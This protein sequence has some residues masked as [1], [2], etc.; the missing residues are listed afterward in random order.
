MRIH[1][2]AALAAVIMLSGCASTNSDT[3]ATPSA[4]VMKMPAPRPAPIN[5]VVF[6]KLKDPAQREALIIDCD[7]M[8]AVIPGT[9]SYYCGTP[10]DTGRGA[11][12]DGNYDVGLY[13]GF[14]T[15]EALNGYVVHPNHVA[16]VEKWRP[17]LE[18]LR[19]HDVIDETR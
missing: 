14:H 13:L 16:L 6:A 8:L 11:S 5:H 2:P 9:A 3:S 18:W 4:G 12:V 17:Q 7:T 19:V 1:Q 10:L 15:V